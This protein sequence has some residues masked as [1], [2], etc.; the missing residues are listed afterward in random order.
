MGRV[1]L[2]RL[3]EFIKKRNKNFN[4]LFKF[5]KDYEKFFILP[6]ATEGSVPSWFSFPL[7]LRDNV[8]FNRLDITLFLEKNRIETRPLFAGNILR[9]PAFKDIEYRVSGTLNNSDKVFKNTFFIGVYPGI[10]EDEM[11]YITSIL[12]KFLN[13]Y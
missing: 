13:K 2:K 6:K 1:Q 11:N 12:R 4:I 8:P 7:T 10:Q 3:P 9:Q 5:F